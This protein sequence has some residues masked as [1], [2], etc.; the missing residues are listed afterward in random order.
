MSKHLLTSDNYAT[1]EIVGGVILILIAVISFAAIYTQLYPAP[2][3]DNINTRIEGTVNQTGLIYLQHTGGETLNSYI[4]EVKSTNNSLIAQETFNKTWDIGETVYPQMQIDEIQ[5]I[6]LLNESDKL[7]ITVKYK[8]NNGAIYQI[9]NGVLTGHTRTSPP[10]SENPMI[11]S[12]LN[13]NSVDEDLISFNY[14]IKPGFNN[15]TYIYN[16]FKN[17]ESLNYLIMPFEINSTT[18]RDYSGNEKHGTAEN[19]TWIKNSLKGGGYQFNGNAYIEI[20]YCFDSNGYI[21]EITVETWIKTTENNVPIAS[22][23]KECLWSLNIKNGLI[24]WATT[25]TDTKEINSETTVNDDSWH[26]V[27]ASFDSTTGNSTIYIDGLKEKTVNCHQ[28]GNN[29]GNGSQPNGFIG[30]GCSKPGRETVFQT[31]FE[32][33]N[34]E[35]KWTKNDGRTTWSGGWFEGYTF[36]RLGSDSLAP[37]NGTYSLGGSGNFDPDYVA[38]DRESIDLSG[39]SNVEISLYYSY[40]S[41]EGDD[42]FCFYYKDGSNWIPIFEENDPDIGEGNQLEWTYVDA[43]IPDS[44]DNLV[45]EFRWSTSSSR[46][47]MAIDDLKITGIPAS[48]ANNFTGDID[49]FQIYKRCLTDE[50]IYQN[51]LQQKNEISDKNV[52]VSDET[53][54]GEKWKC[55]ITPVNQDQYGAT[56]ETD[57]ITIINYGGGI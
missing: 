56:T 39:Y 49:E 3:D 32:T 21:N 8:G 47:Y 26:H 43:Q 37:K 11:I 13:T 15:A 30:K 4:I 22:F 1:S 31:G 24:Q 34:E 57:S 28:P 12:T 29:L 51:Y 17:S 55:N 16:W 35:D 44:L 6:R 41:T 14:Q 42:D 20:P 46:E 25:T 52:I 10:S 2:P 36:G 27:A 48:G 18:V 50:Q 19:A 33:Q 40:K 53:K 23:D 54:A 9:F 5:N 7:K 45:L 38:Y